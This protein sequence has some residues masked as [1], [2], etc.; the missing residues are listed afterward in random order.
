V[1]QGSPGP[2]QLMQ[3]PGDAVDVDEHLAP[4]ALQVVPQHGCPLAPQP[5]QA[6]P[7]QVPL[8]V[9]QALPGL[10]HTLA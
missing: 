6:P 4:A 9:P 10:T 1:Q 5:E 2:P 7:A 8:V 3:V